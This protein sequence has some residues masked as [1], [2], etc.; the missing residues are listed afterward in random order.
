VRFMD[1][2]KGLQSKGAAL[3][4]ITHDRELADRYADRIVRLSD[5]RIVA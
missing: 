4:L 5:G 1:F 3:L 2:I